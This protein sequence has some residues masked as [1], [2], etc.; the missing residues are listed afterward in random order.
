MA[1]TRIDNPL[2]S[3]AAVV[4]GEERSSSSSSNDHD[5]A[6]MQQ[7]KES[8]KTQE[9]ALQDGEQART[10]AQARPQWLRQTLRKV[11]GVHS[12]PI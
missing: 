4:P 12:E 7:Q 6:T 9:G 10:A 3:N 1:T 8:R 5:D 11:E 2:H